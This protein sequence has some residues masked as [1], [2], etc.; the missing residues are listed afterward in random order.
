MLQNKKSISLIAN[1]ENHGITISPNG[2]VNVQFKTIEIEQIL[3][4]PQD[5][6]SV[7]NEILLLDIPL[8]NNCKNGLGAIIN[9]ANEL[10]PN[11]MMLK[12]AIER[13]GDETTIK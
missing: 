4:L 2:K 3:M 9:F 11:A 7:V 5:I 1:H 6:Y 13:L 8:T 12:D 10:Y